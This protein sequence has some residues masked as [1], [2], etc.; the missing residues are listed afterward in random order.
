M[1][2]ALIKISDK[3][4][5]ILNMVKVENDLKDKSEAVEFVVKEYVENEPEFKPS[6][7]RSVLKAEKEKSIPVKDFAKRY[8]LNDVQTRSKRKS[9]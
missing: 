8:G 4:N 5:K 1:V 3:V 2:N 7:I 6:F 9:R